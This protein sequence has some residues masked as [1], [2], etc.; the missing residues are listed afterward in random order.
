MLLRHHAHGRSGRPGQPQAA[1]RRPSH[2]SSNDSAIKLA[3]MRLAATA[4]TGARRG[5]GHRLRR[6]RT[7]TGSQCFLDP[8]EL[9]TFVPAEHDLAEIL[10]TSGSTGLPKGVPLTHRGQLWAIEHYLR[11]ASGRRPADTTLVV[12]PL[13]HMNGLFIID[14]RACATRVAVILL[15]RFERTPLPRDRRPHSVHA[16]CPGS[17]PCLL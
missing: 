15:P 10:Y 2:I 4:R 5:A 9:E 7:Q 1:R 8:G 13:Y 12:A 11:A 16:S 17:P 6:R 3:F 14:R